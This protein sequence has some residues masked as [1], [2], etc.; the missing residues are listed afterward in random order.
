MRSRHFS[1]SIGI[2]V[3]A[4]HDIARSASSQF[5]RNSVFF[6]FFEDKTY[7]VNLLMRFPHFNTFTMQIGYEHFLFFPTSKYIYLFRKLVKS[8]AQKLVEQQLVFISC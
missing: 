7:S 3:N 5:R 4:I 8:Q 6:F 1:I 2:T